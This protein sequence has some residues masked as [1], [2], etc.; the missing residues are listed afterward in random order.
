M[1][2][3]A[4]GR[5]LHEERPGATVQIVEH[6]RRMQ[7]LRLD[8]QCAVWIAIQVHIKAVSSDVKEAK[9][10]NESKDSSCWQSDEKGI[11]TC[12]PL[13]PRFGTQGQI[14]SHGVC[15]IHQ[16]DTSNNLK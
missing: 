9:E 15:A 4:G 11:T 2:R 6:G 12:R 8:K 14:Y 13:N 16:P 3:K 7:R 10:L 1:A 5:S